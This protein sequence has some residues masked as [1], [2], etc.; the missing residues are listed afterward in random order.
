MSPIHR[1][2]LLRIKAGAA[3]ILAGLTHGREPHQR[4]CP[5]LAAFY[6]T[7]RPVIRIPGHRLGDDL[8]GQAEVVKQ[9]L[10][11]LLRLPERLGFPSATQPRSSPGSHVPQVVQLKQRV[12]PSLALRA[13]KETITY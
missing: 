10:G 1:V 11:G 7:G 4:R 3:E 9:V 6:D 5:V 12:S 2:F 8:D 13:G